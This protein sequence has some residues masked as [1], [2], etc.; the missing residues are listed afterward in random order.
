MREKSELRTN[1]KPIIFLVTPKAHWNCSKITFA[2]STQ[3]QHK[4]PN[5]DFSHFFCKPKT[6]SAFNLSSNAKPKP[7][8]IFSPFP[9]LVGLSPVHP[10]E[11]PPPPPR[12]AAPTH[13]GDLLPARERA[14]HDAAGAVGA[15]AGGGG[16]GGGGPAERVGLLAAGGGA[17]RRLERRVPRDRRVGASGE[18]RRGPLRAAQGVDCGVPAAGRVAL[19]LRCC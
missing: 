2:D 14:A 1:T 4:K 6:V 13:G 17:R 12:A 3:Q 19:S 5:S 7:I 11:P 16:S 9:S 18:H 15:G 10:P 8:I